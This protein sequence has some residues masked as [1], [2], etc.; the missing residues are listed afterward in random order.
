MY[1]VTHTSIQSLGL[2]TDDKLRQWA[3]DALFASD[4]ATCDITNGPRL[5]ARPLVRATVWSLT[6]TERAELVRA[7]FSSDTAAATQRMEACRGAV[8]DAPA[9]PLLDTW[10]VAISASPDS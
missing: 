3:A 1:S 8:H 4:M 6:E 7:A 5:Q 2:D 9:W 10:K